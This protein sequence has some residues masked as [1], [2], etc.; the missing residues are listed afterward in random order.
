LQTLSCGALQKKANREVSMTFKSSNN[1]SPLVVLV[2]LL[3]KRS[4]INES[5]LARKRQNF[6]LSKRFPVRH[7]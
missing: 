7:A 4:S 3:L 2:R 6:E 1:S 5:R